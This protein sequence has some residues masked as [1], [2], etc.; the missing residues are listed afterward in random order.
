MK[1]ARPATKKKKVV[2]N[3]YKT[4]KTGWKTPPLTP[5]PPPLS[6]L[7]GF[8]FTSAPVDQL[9][10]TLAAHLDSVLAKTAKFDGVSYVFEKGGR[11]TRVAGLKKG[12]EARH[13]PHY[14]DNRAPRNWKTV[15]I[16]G[17]DAEEGKYVDTELAL[18]AEEPG[19]KVDHHMVRK[20]LDTFREMGHVTVAGQVP[21]ELPS[22]LMGGHRMTQADLITRDDRTG[23]LWLW[24]QKCGAP[25]GFNR[26]QG[27]FANLPGDEEVVCTKLGI[28][29][30]QLRY[31]LLSLR[32]AGVNIR[33]SRVSQI[34]EKRG[35]GLF[36]DIHPPPEW[37]DRL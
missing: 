25:V 14:I 5:P 33:H 1:R 37:T 28:W 31:T 19:R 7:T 20:M 34:Y 21:V 27:V 22:H 4:H 3:K 30:L 32:A 17:S 8:H 15:R 10:P 26:K 35:L 23:E 29:H 9:E 36:V 12:L 24:E 11:P 2:H 13:Y 6:K 18:H 16:M